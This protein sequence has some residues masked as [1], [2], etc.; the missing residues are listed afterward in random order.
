MFRR[1]AAQ[2]LGNSSE[3]ISAHVYVSPLQ[4]SDY[5]TD[6]DANCVQ[7]ENFTNASND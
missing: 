1:R 4:Q 5:N 3:G 6:Y 2:D 7:A